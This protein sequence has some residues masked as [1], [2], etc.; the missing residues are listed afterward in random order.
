MQIAGTLLAVCSVGAFFWWCWVH[1]GNAG[2]GFLAAALG[3]VAGLALIIQDRMTELLLPVLLG[4]DQAAARAGGVPKCSDS[5]Q[6]ETRGGRWKAPRA[7]FRA[8]LQAS[9]GRRWPSKPKGKRSW[10]KERR[11]EALDKAIGE[12]MRPRRSQV[13]VLIPHNCCGGLGESSTVK[14]LRASSNCSIDK[15]GPLS[16]RAAQ[17]WKITVLNAHFFGTVSVADP[18][19]EFVFDRS[20][21]SFL[22]NSGNRNESPEIEKPGLIQYIWLRHDI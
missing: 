14:P 2:R 8:A 21:L 4:H 5:S 6:A 10:R 9:V 16:A 7:R 3:V 20:K 18:P 19:V 17:A 12:C 1:E 15:S 11:S 13:I 22:I